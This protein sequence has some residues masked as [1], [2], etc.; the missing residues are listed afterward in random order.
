VAAGIRHR[1]SENHLPLLGRC[2]HCNTPCL[3]ANVDVHRPFESCHRCH[4][5][6]GN[7]GKEVD[8][9]MALQIELQL[10]FQQNMFNVLYC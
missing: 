10:E 8:R 1:L 9:E 6:L 7:M 2:D 4:R 5:H 3:F